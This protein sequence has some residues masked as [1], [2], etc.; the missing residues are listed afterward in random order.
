[1]VEA[2]CLYNLVLAT[3]KQEIL[4]QKGIKWTKQNLAAYFL[5]IGIH[6]HAHYFSTFI[7][8]ILCVFHILHLDPIHFPAPSYL[9][10]AL[11][12]LLKNLRKQKLKNS[13]W[14]L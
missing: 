3:K 11:E 2:C 4:L 12:P 1:M 7:S 8:F 14:N 13:S 9:P 6:M 5:P 10:S